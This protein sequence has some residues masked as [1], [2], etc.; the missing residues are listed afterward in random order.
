[1]C[2][3]VM[4][5]LLRYIHTE[6]N[7]VR[8]SLYSAA[9]LLCSIPWMSLRVD[10][11]APVAL[12][13]LLQ[14]SFVS[15]IMSFSEDGRRTAEDF[16]QK[17]GVHP[18]RMAP[19]RFVS[20][21]GF[22]QQAAHHI[23]LFP[24]TPTRLEDDVPGME[25]TYE[26][27]AEAY[28]GDGYIHHFL[29][30][31]YQVDSR[32]LPD[33]SPSSS[34]EER[35]SAA[36]DS[37]F[38]TWHELQELFDKVPVGTFDRGD[39]QV[40]T[41]GP[42]KPPKAFTTGA[43]SRSAFHGLRRDTCVYPWLTSLLCSIVRNV[44]PRHK[45][46]TISWARNVMTVVHKDSHNDGASRNLILPCSSFTQ[47]S[48]WLE[49]SEGEVMISAAGPRGQLWNTR[50]ADRLSVNDVRLL[51]SLGFYP[52]E[53]SYSARSYV[54]ADR[55]LPADSVAIERESSTVAT[56]ATAAEIKYL[57]R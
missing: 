39:A 52:M 2:T 21:H 54:L 11:C 44:A 49:D 28:M 29:R 10:D 45:F 5:A 14:C 47:G 34:V 36:M 27:T 23:G 1:M 46:T 38:I 26:H 18:Y 22:S 16:E 20:L 56:K 6:L 17:H 25:Y 35:A 43:Y 7:V 30:G 33:N 12:L 24:S 57:G 19:E 40:G 9:L 51:C 48:L 13:I 8:H 32:C 53:Y 3:E 15:G 31:T 50:N 55:L 42:M 37:G 4:R 41:D